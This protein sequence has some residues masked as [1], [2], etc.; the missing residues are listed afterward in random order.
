MENARLF[1]GRDDAVHPPEGVTRR[2]AACAGVLGSAPLVAESADFPES[3]APGEERDDPSEDAA[4]EAIAAMLLAS[5]RSNTPPG[6]V[7]RRDAHPKHHAIVRAEFQVEA[8]LPA[9]LRHGLFAA[10]RSY[11]AW[12]RLSNGSPRIRSDG[13]R[14]QRGLAIKLLDVPG[15]KV[16]PDEADASTQD[17]VLASYPRFFIRSVADY[18]AFTRAAATRRK[19]TLFSY[20]FQG[21]PW[22]WRIHELRAL[23]GSLQPAGDLLAL[24]YWSQTAYRLGPHAVKYS[25]GPIAGGGGAAVRPERSA[26]FLRERLAARLA[27]APAQLA[28]LVQRRTDPASMP[29]EDATLEWSEARAPFVRVATITIPVQ[30]FDSV[31]QMALA[32]QMAFTPWHTLP[33]HRPLGGIN[34]ARRT[35]YQVVSQL[36]S[37]LNGVV[38]REPTSLD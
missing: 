33:D 24:R 26:D 1:V 12:I 7:A 21:P 14:D 32:E 27:R 28:F 38:R 8:D 31:E 22:R 34:R 37:E 35:L 10:P 36:R 18:V 30:R 23:L 16:L 25:V 17:F 13:K 19:S 20:F 4:I 6:S 11:P 9:D 29:I 5:V 3:L 2:P 15:R